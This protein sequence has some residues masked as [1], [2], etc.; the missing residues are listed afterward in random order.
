MSVIVKKC[1][2]DLFAEVESGRKKFDLRVADFPAQAGD[3]L[4]LAEYDP[5][6]KEYT[7]RKIEKTITFV[8]K[9]DPANYP[10]APA[11]DVNKFG[12]QIFSLE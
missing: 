4:V 3:I 8:L 2:P 12:L 11:E 1:W 9:F 10:F 6:K 5:E 7:G